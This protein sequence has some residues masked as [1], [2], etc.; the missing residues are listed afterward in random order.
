MA[1]NKR[2]GALRESLH[3]QKRGTAGDGFGNNVPGQGPWVT[4]F[5][6]AASMQ[7]LRGTESVMAARLNG[8]QPYVVA[9]RHN[10]AMRGVTPAWRCVDQRNTNRV[11]DIASPLADPDGK[12]QWLEFIA[13]EGTPGAGEVYPPLA[14]PVITTEGPI[15]SPTGGI[16]PIEGTGFVTATIL[17]SIGDITDAVDVASDGTWTWQPPELSDGIYQLTVTQRVAHGPVSVASAPLQITIDTIAPAAPVITTAGPLVTTN[18][19]PEMA[20]TAEA[21]SLVTIYLAGAPHDTTEADAGGAWDYEFDELDV[22][23][24]SVTATAT[25]AAGNE[26]AP[27]PALML[28]I[29]ALPQISGAPGTVTREGVAYSFVPEV[30]GG[31]APF[32][33][34][35][36]AGTLP[37]GLSINPGTGE[38]SGEPTSFGLFGGIVIRVTDAEENTADLPAFDLLS[39]ETLR[40]SGTP[41]TEA[42]E[43]EAYEFFATFTGGIGPYEPYSENPAPGMQLEIVGM[44]VR[45]FGPLTEAGIFEGI[46]IGVEDSE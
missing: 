38:L 43:G 35:L 9:V 7:P 6:V 8:K 17:I 16:D 21:L 30:T 18:T 34:T 29:R 36:N 14:A 3:F 5:T 12:R 19:S 46:V 39:I 45:V 26:S 27:S 28:D 24:Y 10:D 42:V 1:N 40:I 11:F 23:V 2:H 41:L 15:I 44:Q 20:G 33:F 25:D 31:V 22:A 37:E 13:I 4:Q 32:V